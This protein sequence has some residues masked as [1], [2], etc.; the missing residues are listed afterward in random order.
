VTPLLEEMRMTT[1]VAGAHRPGMEPGAAERWM[2]FD[3]E[4]IREGDVRISVRANALHQGTGVLEGIRAYWN[5][6][7]GQLYLLEGLAHY[8]RLQRSARIIRMS[9]PETPE[10]LVDVTCELLRRNGCRENTYIRPLFF[11]SGTEM[12][13]DMLAATDSLA[14]YTYPLGRFFDGDT[15]I[16]CM[17][18]SWRRIPDSVIPARAKTTASYLNSVLAKTESVANGF[19]E[20]IMLTC[21]GHVCESST[22]NIFVLRDGRFATPGVTDDILEGITRR[23]LMTL[24]RD[25]LG[26]E[27]V[28][29]SIDRTE[30]Y[31]ADEMFICGTG[32]G[33]VPIAS[34]DHTPVGAERIGP[35]TGRLTQIYERCV[36]GDE[37]R[38]AHWLLPVHP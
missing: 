15:G 18:S 9:L 12:T 23:L 35:H 11:K 4:Y 29:R 26:I 5:A 8:Q 16:R 25:E 24:I 7:R 20:A 27:V 1:H 21:D 13:V 2:F 30:L 14:V 33:I 3:G 38:Y 17:V 19:D 6:A 37:A 32:I 22:S 34:V 28:E 10:R 36:A 31:C